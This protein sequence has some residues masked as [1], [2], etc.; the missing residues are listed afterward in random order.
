MPES[1]STTVEIWKPI[2]GL[3][4]YDASSLGRIRGITKV[5]V[6]SIHT[7]GYLQV[8]VR[9]PSGKGFVTRT[10][11]R[12]VL[13][14]FNGQSRMHANHKNC[15]K[16]DNR[17]ENLEYVT[18]SQNVTHSYASGLRSVSHQGNGGG[19]RKRLSV[20]DVEQIRRLVHGGSLS[21]REIGRIFGIRHCRVRDVASGE[22]QVWLR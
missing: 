4:G 7:A 3:A 11:H 19:R 9:R 12:L 21:L 5:L 6:P 17:I 15:D 22:H 2:P 14:A 10:V 13:A 18:R 20:E 1:Q 16:H 8:S